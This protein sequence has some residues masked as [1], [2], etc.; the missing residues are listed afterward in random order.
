MEKEQYVT[1]IIQMEWMAFDAVRNKGGRAA[2]Q[3]DWDTFS[4]MRR[5]QYEVWDEEVLEF[6]YEDLHLA[7][8][9]GRNLIMEKYARM[10]ESTVPEEY[11]EIADKLPQLPEEFR[12]ILEEIVSI[13]VKW[14]EEFAE[15]Y[16]KM[17][18]RARRIRSSEDTAAETSYET[19]LR[20]EL[21]TYSE[22]T[23]LAYGRFIVSMSRCGENLAKKIMEKTAQL[24]GYES[25]QEAEAALQ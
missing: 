19:Y 24:Y 12:A 2:C 25:L 6:Y 23:L 9:Q 14:M 10:M 18:G 7:Q 20:G 1:E 13:Q 22:Q 11:Q 15:E 21:C 16:P 3:N 5:S 4:I 17:A 8:Q